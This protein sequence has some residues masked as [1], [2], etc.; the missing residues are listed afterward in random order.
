MSS[1]QVKDVPAELHA[2]LRRRAARAGQ[3][4]QEY[5]LARLRE[6]AETQTLS[7]ALARIEHR[8]GGNVSL[9]VA[10]VFRRL[11]ASGRLTPQRASQALGDLSD[12]R[13]ERVSHR[14]L[15]RRCWELRHDIT[16]YDAAYVALAEALDATL[17]TAD[18]HLTRAP[19]V[20]CSFELLI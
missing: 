14:F 8:S 5:L 4:L 19:N 18:Q 1:I 20:R 11:C 6:D 16:V 13:L 7:E 2:V 9:E 10:S 17:L 12:L 3:S 15:I